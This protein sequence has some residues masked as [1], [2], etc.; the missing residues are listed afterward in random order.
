MEQLKVLRK[1]LQPNWKEPPARINT[2]NGYLLFDEIF[3][4]FSSE[5][6]SSAKLLEDLTSTRG[7]DKDGGLDP[8]QRSLMTLR[9]QLQASNS[10]T[11]SRGNCSEKL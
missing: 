4:F 7:K 5:L 9:G 1:K 8:V 6:E 10:P 3:D 2:Y 11:N